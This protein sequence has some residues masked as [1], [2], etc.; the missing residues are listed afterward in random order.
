MNS[1]VCDFYFNINLSVSSSNLKFL[2]I[3]INTDSHVKSTELF[4]LNN[5]NIK[6]YF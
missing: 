1:P 2:L 4:R 3:S 6:Q 5:L